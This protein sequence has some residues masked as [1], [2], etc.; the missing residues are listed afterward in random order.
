LD[1]SGNCRINVKA[2]ESL[3]HIV[4]NGKDES[5]KQVSSGIYFYNL[6]NGKYSFTRKMLLIE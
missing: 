2:T 3:S 1:L 4:W 6:K 5:G